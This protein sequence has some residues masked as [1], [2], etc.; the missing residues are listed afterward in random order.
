MRVHKIAAAIATTAAASRRR[1][2]PPLLSLIT[3]LVPSMVLFTALLSQRLFDSCVEERGA[4][5]WI[6]RGRRVES[7][8]ES[9]RVEFLLLATLFESIQ[10]QYISNVNHNVLAASKIEQ[11]TS[12]IYL[13]TLY[14]FHLSHSHA[15][16]QSNRPSNAS[17][18]GCCKDE[19]L[20][21]YH[22]PNPVKALFGN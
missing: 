20:P 17:R 14:I 2:I 5:V 16:R 18:K 1:Q 10:K 7:R 15:I 13:Y 19:F 4:S 11:H 8:F 22:L 6:K 21:K 3:H 12:T 9:S